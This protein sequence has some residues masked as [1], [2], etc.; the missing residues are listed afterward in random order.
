MIPSEAAEPALQVTEAAE[1]TDPRAAAAAPAQP[2]QLAAAPSAAA[3]PELEEP[4]G[5]R[6]DPLALGEPLPAVPGEMLP[7]VPTRRPRPA[8]SV[9]FPDRPA[10]RGLPPPAENRL[11]PSGKPPAGT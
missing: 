6:P 8:E 9:A 4:Q 3:S 2:A 10:E 7:A 5:R 1:S 11:R